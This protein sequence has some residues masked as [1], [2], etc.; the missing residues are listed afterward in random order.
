[1][2]VKKQMEIVEYFK[3]LGSMITNDVTCTCKG[4]SRVSIRK[5][6]VQQEDY[7]RVK[8]T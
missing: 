3:Y 8:W 6:G 4:K 7:S 1:M 2:I 5:I